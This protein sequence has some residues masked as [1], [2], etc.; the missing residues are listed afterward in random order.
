MGFFFSHFFGTLMG[1]HACLGRHIA[2]RFR[3]KYEWNISDFIG[4]DVPVD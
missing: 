4:S 2:T 1:S 3:V